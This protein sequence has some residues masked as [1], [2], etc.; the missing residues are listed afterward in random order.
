[1]SNS[2]RAADR[3][4]A[5]FWMLLLAGFAIF[6]VAGAWV[7]DDYGVVM[8]EVMKRNLAEQAAAYVL[9]GDGAMFTNWIRSDGVVFELGQWLLIRLLGL[10]DSRDVYLGYHMIS[11]LFFLCAGVACAILSY[12]VTGSRAAA[13]VA[14]LL[15]VLHP[16]LYAH[17]FVNTKDVPFL[18]LFM[19]SLFLIHNAFRKDAMGAFALCGACVA[20]AFNT[21]VMAFVL[22]LAVLGMRGLDMWFAAGRAERRRVLATAAVFLAVFAAV[23]YATWPRL[24][25]EPATGMFEAFRWVLKTF[26]VLVVFEGEALSSGDVPRRYIPTLIGLTTPPFTLLLGLAGTAAAVGRVAR[27]PREALR[28][29]PLRFEC[30]CL[31]ASWGAVTA[32]VAGGANLYNGWRPLYFLVAPLSVLGALGLGS[33]LAALRRPAVR[34]AAGGLALAAAGSSAVAMAEIHPYQN[35]YFNLLADRET[36]EGLRQ[37]Y[38]LD[39]WATSYREALEHMLERHPSST[40]HVHSFDD[41]ALVSNRLVLAPEDRRRIVVGAQG[42]ADYYI[43]NHREHY[44]AAEVAPPM[45]APMVYSRQVYNNTIMSVTATNVVMVDDDT[46]EQYRSL[47]ENVMANRPIAEGRA[48][49]FLDDLQLNFAQERCPRSWLT[50]YV[51]L[52]LWPRAWD[53]DAARRARLRP[54]FG[55]HGVLLDGTCW[56]VIELPWRPARLQARLTLPHHD[57]RLWD[58]E[59]RLDDERD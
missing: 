15:F 22:V 31:M 7:V 3:T 16:R 43:T 47:Y 23:T 42:M 49:F 24:W 34:R 6:V 2:A 28:N 48:R 41:Q 26:H 57:V 12:R 37:Q 56:A 30:L 59:I 17:S 46:G 18:G 11:H 58:A 25:R 29:T 32:L 13:C 5:D 9:A 54:P 55:S 45:P 19:I 35:V 40:V 8:D 27:R 52:R 50:G 53:G 4:P 20:L 1:M 14:F 36:P 39:Y 21:R 33:T 38:D 10:E 51:D 44:S